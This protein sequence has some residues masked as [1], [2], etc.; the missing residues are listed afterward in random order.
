MTRA[1]LKHCGKMPDA[2]EALDR[3][4]REE[5]IESGHSNLNNY[6]LFLGGKNR[7]GKEECIGLK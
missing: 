4:M 6:C 5:I 2:R 7:I 1:D 3:S